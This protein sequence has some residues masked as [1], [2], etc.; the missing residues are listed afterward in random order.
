METF[1][2]VGGSPIVCNLGKDIEVRGQFDYILEAAGHFAKQFAKN[3]KKKFNTGAC[4]F[5][6]ILK[7][8]NDQELY[9]FKTYPEDIPTKDSKLILRWDM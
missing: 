3:Y 4:S 7:K 9:R 6:F 2:L 1:R 5:R 8:D